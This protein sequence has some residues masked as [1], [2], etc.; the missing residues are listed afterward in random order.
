[1]DFGVGDIK[2]G[3]K[4][5][6]EDIIKCRGTQKVLLRFYFQLFIRYLVGT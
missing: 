2:T 5:L 3:K 4:N 6:L 1:M